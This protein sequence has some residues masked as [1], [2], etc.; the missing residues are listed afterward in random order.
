MTTKEVLARAHDTYRGSVVI[1]PVSTHLY[2][3]LV[4][5]PDIIHSP[6]TFTVESKHGGHSV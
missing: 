2:F 1:A 3:A 5:H 4:L 6:V